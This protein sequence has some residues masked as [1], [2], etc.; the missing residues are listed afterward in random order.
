MLKRHKGLRRIVIAR[1]VGLFI[2]FIYVCLLSCTSAQGIAT[3]ADTADKALEEGPA[4]FRDIHDSCVRRH[5]DAQP[6]S[7]DFHA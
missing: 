6:I 2:F 7:A 1:V 5:A 4:I 3:F